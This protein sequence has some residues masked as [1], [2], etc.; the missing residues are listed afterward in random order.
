MAPPVPHSHTHTHT[1]THTQSQV[2]VQAWTTQ[3][4]GVVER[5][6]SRS[7]YPKQVGDHLFSLDGILHAHPA[8]SLYLVNFAEEQAPPPL[9]KG[10]FN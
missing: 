1:H 8:P 5:L 2:F 6:R 7:F 10:V 4:K 3:G 9:S